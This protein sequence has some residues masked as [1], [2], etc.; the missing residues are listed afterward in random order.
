M[1]YKNKQK[2]GLKAVRW[3][4]QI[5]I[6]SGALSPSRMRTRLECDGSLLKVFLNN[7]VFLVRW[8]AMESSIFRQC[9]KFTANKHIQRT[10]KP[11][12]PFAKKRKSHAS[13][14]SP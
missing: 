7:A 2:T 3:M 6:G 12:A 9:S 10:F 11:V 14:E 1:C 13:F 4:L 5:V 8:F